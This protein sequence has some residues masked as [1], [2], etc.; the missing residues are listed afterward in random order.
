MQLIDDKDMK[1]LPIFAS[2]K[3]HM[4]ALKNGH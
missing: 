1:M 3:K 2:L 4:V